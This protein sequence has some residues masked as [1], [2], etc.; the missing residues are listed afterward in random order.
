MKSYNSLNSNKTNSKKD[1]LKIQSKYLHYIKDNF[2]NYN[3]SKELDIKSKSKSK[4]ATENSKNSIRNEDYN[5]DENSIDTNLNKYNFDP[6][7]YINTNKEKFSND[8]IYLD[9]A[10]SKTDKSKKIDFSEN[11][12]NKEYLNDQLNSGTEKNNLFL[13]QFITSKKSPKLED[14]NLLYAELFKNRYN[15]KVLEENKINNISKN[16][17]ELE[18]KPILNKHSVNIDQKQY[19]DRVLK[20]VLKAK[21]TQ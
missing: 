20:A 2:N 1:K 6:K 15:S 8:K 11:Y 17:N 12:N 16:T 10:T 3:L 13:N 9:L 21:G 4:I 14:S 19:N 7:I 5:K 18:F